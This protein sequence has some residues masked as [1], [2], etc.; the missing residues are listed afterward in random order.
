M[1][2]AIPVVEVRGGKYLIV[3]HFGRSPYFL[4]AEVSSGAYKV[5]EVVRNP[6]A[7]GEGHG[8][9]RTVI[10]YLISKGV[11][12][13]I[14]KHLGIPAYSHLRELGV[15]VLRA[16]GEYA[17]DSLKALAEGRLED[18]VPEEGEEHETHGHHHH[19]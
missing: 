9:G 8:R 4:I 13:V 1:R 6:L 17:E 14:V 19:H 5:V 16:S 12:A 11:E 10:S 3:P 15:R 18:Y 7:T 2:V